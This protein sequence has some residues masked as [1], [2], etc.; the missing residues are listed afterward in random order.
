VRGHAAG[1]VALA[2]G[3]CT[4]TAF[5]AAEDEAARSLAAAETAFAQ[6]SVREG[7]RAAFISHF[8]PDV[9]FVRKGWTRARAYL[10]DRPDPPIVLDWRPAYV[11]TAGSGELG[12]STGPWKLASRGDPAAAA[13][14]GQFI[15]IWKRERDGPWRVAV[16]LGVQHAPPALW[17]QPLETH[18]PAGAGASATVTDAESRFA[19]DAAA[20]GAAS[21]YAAHLA[22]NVRLYRQGEPPALGRRDA[23]GLVE[24]ESGERR[25][26][27]ERFETASSR[28]FGYALGHYENASSPGITAGHFLRVWRFEP[29]GW[30]I[31]L[32]VLQPASS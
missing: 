4:M 30:R 7:M 23:L 1:V 16:D 28:D 26:S 27:V 2:L 31:A 14:Y 29:A 21:A 32:E 13:T 8:A 24:R 15:S 22:A 19:A 3:G 20:R 12:L 5:L 10:Q 11:E 17:D 18:A 6:Q 9:L 25:W